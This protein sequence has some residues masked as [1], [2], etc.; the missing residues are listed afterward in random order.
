MLTI[1]NENIIENPLSNFELS[2]ALLCNNDIHSVQHI[3]ECCF[4]LGLSFA[5]LLFYRFY[6]KNIC[7]CI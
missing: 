5:C 6:F 2:K 7:L 3:T 4:G 1:F